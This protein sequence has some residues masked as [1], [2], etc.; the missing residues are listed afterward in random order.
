MARNCDKKNS[1]QK[2]KNKCVSV[3]NVIF[4]LEETNQKPYTLI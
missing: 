1:M 3:Y 4:T 2:K